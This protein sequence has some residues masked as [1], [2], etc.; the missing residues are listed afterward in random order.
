MVQ[1]KQSSTLTSNMF[2]DDDESLNLS[3]EEENNYQHA[4]TNVNKVGSRLLDDNKF[5]RLKPINSGNIP[6]D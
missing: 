6:A 3:S 2:S 4:K 1:L 5:F